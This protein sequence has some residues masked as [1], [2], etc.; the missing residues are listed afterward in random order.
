MFIAF[1][2]RMGLLPVCELVCVAGCHQPES[3]KLN[4]Q[5]VH[6]KLENK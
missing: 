2:M 5:H 6:K 4:Q 1:K 3:C